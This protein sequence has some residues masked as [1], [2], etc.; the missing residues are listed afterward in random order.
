MKSLAL[1]AL[2]L[3]ATASTTLAHPG[4]HGPRAGVTSRASLA[5]YVGGADGK[6]V[7]ASG[8]CTLVIHPAGGSPKVVTA[9]LVPGD[10]SEKSGGGL[11]HGG[12]VIVQGERSVELVLIPEAQVV[13]AGRGWM[14]LET[15]SDTSGPASFRASLAGVNFGLGG[16]AFEATVILR[17]GDETTKVPGFVYPR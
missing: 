17:S 16:L 12:Q 8:T 2:A 15:E 6:Q 4:G 9:E 7:A 5:I 14:A 10:G 13:Q 1:I 3:I 11:D